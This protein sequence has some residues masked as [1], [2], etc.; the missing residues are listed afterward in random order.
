MI[1]LRCLLLPLTIL[2]S[3]GVVATLSADTPTTGNWRTDA[4]QA[5]LSAQQDQRLMLLFIT[6]QN[7]LYCRKMEHD[8]FADRKVVWGI[9]QNC[10][11]VT[12]AAE[13]NGALVKKLRVN[14][15]PTTVIISPKS[16]VVDYIVGYLG[17]DEFSRRLDAATR[18]TNTAA[19]TRAQTTR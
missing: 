14:T 8:T 7:C 17:P 18:R 16:G 1:R 2:L 10:V 19:A 4:D 3:A 9:Q 12:I 5:W 6:T 15:Y 13:K 11:P